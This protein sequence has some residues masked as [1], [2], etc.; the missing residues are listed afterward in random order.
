MQ[1]SAASSSRS[2]GRRAS[3][4]RRP[5]AP[6]TSAMKRILTWRKR[7]GIWSV[8]AGW[9]ST[10]MWFPASVVARERLLDHGKSSTLP[11]LELDA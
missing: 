10:R 7:Y 1:K 6:N 2:P 4:A 9:T 8:A 5:A 11:S 3:T